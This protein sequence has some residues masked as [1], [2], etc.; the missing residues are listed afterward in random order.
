[1]FPSREIESFYRSFKDGY[2]IRDEFRDVAALCEEWLLSFDGKEPVKQAMQV[3]NLQPSDYSNDDRINVALSLALC[4][5][6][7]ATGTLFERYDFDIG[8]RSF[9]IGSL[10]TEINKCL[11]D[12]GKVDVLRAFDALPGREYYQS[13]RQA[14]MCD[15]TDV[16]MDAVAHDNLKVFKN[17]LDGDDAVFAAKT[18]MGAL[19][20]FLEKPESAIHQALV[21]DEQGEK[22]YFHHQVLKLRQFYL[23]DYVEQTGWLRAEPGETAT[24]QPFHDSTLKLATFDEITPA[25][26]HPQLAQKLEVDKYR[27]ASKFFYVTEFFLEDVKNIEG[28]HEATRAFM[29]A[30]LT[31]RYIL[32]HALAKRAEDE[33]QVSLKEALARLGTLN[34]TN[35]AIYAPVFQDFL[36][37]FTEQQILDACES[38]ETLAGV[39]KLT[40]NKAFL[41]G[42]RG[43]A[44][45]QCLSSDLG[46]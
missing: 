13:A 42:S 31:S 16:R 30:G 3:L 2:F 36:G 12:N 7:Q 27:L 28:F 17:T 26:K 37:Q 15:M 6:S 39:F 10:V 5:P 35:Q 22:D 21:H 43:S 9:E 40:R 44:I 24:L 29:E 46:L 33:P 32:T 23:G 45:D 1:M 8:Q 20:S 34:A 25:H 18:A 14:Y 19:T 4:I 41:L 11:P 38:D